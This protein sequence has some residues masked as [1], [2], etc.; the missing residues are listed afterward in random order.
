MLLETVT[1]NSS[2]FEP[3][4]IRIPPPIPV[5]ELL[6]M[7]TSVMRESHAS[8]LMPPPPTLATLFKIFKFLSLGLEFSIRIP[9]PPVMVVY[10]LVKVSPVST[11][12]ESSP[13]MN[14]ATLL[15]ASPS[16]MVESI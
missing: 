7:T 4:N 11:A 2:G 9:P 15:D 3:L 16:M 1:P 13:E 12:V 6:A 5:T 8:Q 14:V 10:P